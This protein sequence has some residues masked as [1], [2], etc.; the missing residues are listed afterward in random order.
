MCV[1]TCMHVCV[2]H[3]CGVCVCAYVCIHVCGCVCVHVFVCVCVCVCVHKHTL[4]MVSSDKILC[5]RNTLNIIIVIFL[6]Y[7]YWMRFHVLVCVWVCVHFWMCVC[8]GVGEIV[9]VCLDK[10]HK[11]LFLVFIHNR[12]LWASYIILPLFI[13]QR[14]TEEVVHRLNT[15]VQTIPLSDRMPRDDALVSMETT[16]DLQGA[17]DFNRPSYMMRYYCP[18]Y[19]FGIW[20]H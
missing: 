1:C 15:R 14:K 12:R 11:A 2:V 3:V 20:G 6:F 17:V 8:V 19:A 10:S 18:L 7:V 4:R 13:L 9:Y 5:F 16:I